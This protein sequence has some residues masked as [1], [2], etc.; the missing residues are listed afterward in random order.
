M[1]R[2]RVGGWATFSSSSLALPYNRAYH[3]PQAMAAATVRAAVVVVVEVIEEYPG[4]WG[5]RRAASAV[6]AAFA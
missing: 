6:T 2:C 3:D 1:V 4:G 5:G